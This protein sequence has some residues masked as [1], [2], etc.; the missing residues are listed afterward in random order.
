MQ[1]NKLSIYAAIETPLLP[2]LQGEEVGYNSLE[3]ALQTQAATILGYCEAQ[4]KEPA[5]FLRE[6]FLQFLS[7]FTGEDQEP[8]SADSAAPTDVP[9]SL[10][11]GITD[12]NLTLSATYQSNLY[13]EF[14]IRQLIE[15]FD[16]L[17]GQLPA[18]QC[19]LAEADFTSQ[20]QRQLLDSFNQ[21]DVPYDTTQTI[22]SLFRRQ[23]AQT[24][25]R[26]AVVYHDLS[27]TY[28]AVDELSER[29]AQ[30]ILSLGLKSEEVVS[31]L[32]PRSQWMVIASLGVLKAGCAYQPLDPSYPSE[33]LNFMMKDAKAR[34]LIAS[35]ELRALVD[36]Y[37]GEVLLTKDI[38][39]LP[40]AAAPVQADITP[41]SLFIL[42]YTSGSTGV[43]KGCQLEHG[44]LVAFCHWY[45][46]YYELTSEG[47]VA[48][49]ASYGFDAC[50]MDM[51]PALTCGAC[52]Y[53]IGDDIRLNLPEL[54][55]YFEANGITHSFITTQVGYQFAVNMENHTLKHFIVGG[56]KLSALEPPTTYKMHNGYG[57]T[58]CT[59]FTTNYWVHDYELD[60][61][62]GKPLDN[63]RLYIVD[64]Q[65]HRLPPGAS[66]ELWVGGPQ[67]SRGYLNHPDKTTEVF[68]QNPFDNDPLH[69]RVYRTGDIVR[70]LADGNIQF[71]GRKDSQ[72]KVR[73]FRIELKEVEAIIR[74]FPGIK[75]V[76][77]QAFDE[78]GGGKFLA[79]YI[80]S[81]QQVDIQALNQFIMEE[82]PPFMVPAV[83]MQIDSI[84]LNV[85][86]K[87]DRKALPKPERESLEIGGQAEEEAAPLNVLEQELKAMVAEI[88]GHEYFG[89]TT[90]LG[91][92]G[93]TSITAIRLAIQINKRFGVTL[94]SRTLAKTGTL[95]SIENEVLKKLLLEEPASKDA[96]EEHHEL[97]NIPLSYAQIGVYVDCIKQPTSIAYNLPMLLPFPKDTDAWQLRAALKTLITAHPELR[98]NFGSMGSEIVQTVDLEQP[99]DIAMSQMTEEELDSYKRCFARPFNLKQDP[100]YRFEIVTT[101]AHVN[102][103]FDIHHLVVDGSSINLLLHQ[104]CD[105]L[106]GGELEPEDL[107]YADYVIQE[108]A[109][110]GGADYQAARDFFHSQLSECEGITEVPSDLTNPHDEGNTATEACALDF[111]Q[112]EN[113]CRQQNITPA[114]LALAGVFYALSRFTNQERLCL[115]TISNGRSNLRISNTV[116]MFVNTLALSSRVTDQRVIDFLLQTSRN[117]DETIQHENYPFAQIAADYDLSPEIMYAYQMG[118]LDSYK[119]RGSEMMLETLQPESNN[120]PLVFFI[121][122]HEGKPSVCI[123]YDDGLYSQGLIQSLAQSVRNAI[124]AFM[125]QPEGS[126]L[127]V[128]LLDE[129]QTQLLDSFNETDEPFDTTQTVV[130]LFREQVKRSPDKMAVVFHDHR[131]TYREVDEITDRLAGYILSKGLKTEDVVSILIPRSEWMPLAALGVLKAG[132]AYQPLDPSYPTERLNFMVKD[133]NA[134]LLIADET[135]C[136]LVDEYEGD[137]L[138]TR[139]ILTCAPQVPV[140]VEPKPEDLFNLLY[141]SGSTGVPKGCQLEH[142]NVVAFCHM[143]WKAQHLTAESRIGAYA[144]FGFDA[145]VME[146]FSALTLGAELHIIPEEIRL[147]LAALNDY[148]AQNGLTH[149][150]MTTQVAYQFATNFENQSLKLLLA[151]GEKLSALNPPSTYTMANGYGPSETICFVT[152]YEV[153]ERE[154][155]IPIGKAQQ[156]FKCYVVDKMGH[157]LP[158]G[159]SGELWVA[160]PQVTR[161]YLNR[162]EKTAE[163][164]IDNPFNTEEKYARVY[165]TGD[166]VRYLP[167]GNL[168]YVGRRDGQVKI[169]GFRIELKE[170]EAVIRQFPGIKDATVQAFEYESGGKY[171]AAYIVSDEEVNIKELNAFIGKQKP[172]YMIPAAT[173]QIDAI[174][175]TQNQK[176]NRKA[177]PTP[178]ISA[179]DHAYVAPEGELEELFCKIFGDILLMDKIGANDSFFELGGTSLMVTRVMIE[180][181]KNHH[182]IAYGDLFSHPTPRQLAAFI[183]GDTETKKIN[184]DATY[185]YTAINELLSHN[186]LESF[187]DG[188]RQQIGNVLLTGA[189]GYL[190]IHI[191]RD[192]IERDD[193]PIIWCLV[194]AADVDK[195]EHRLRGLLFYYF[196]QS[197]KDLFGTRLRIVLGDVTEDIAV[198]GKVDTVFNCAAIVKH[199]SKGTEI[200]DVNIGGAEHCVKFCL[201]TGAKLVHV[202][203]Y[204]TA[205]LSVDGVPAPETV[206]TE[207]ML[208]FGQYLDNQYLHSKFISERIVLE[209]VAKHQ[210]RAKVVRLG[211][212]APRSTDGEFQINFQTNSAMGRIRV[213][214][215]LGCYPYEMTDEPMEFSPI[216]E[217]AHS[218]VL[219][220]ETPREC[221]VFHPFNNH[222]VFFGDVL[223][224]LGKIGE[225]PRQVEASQF[226]EVLEEAKQ[227]PEKAK[228]LSSMLAYQDM[229]HGQEAFEIPP[230]NG[231]TTQVL[232]RLGFRWSTTSWDYVDQFLTAIDGMGY[233]DL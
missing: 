232:Y 104:L 136:I 157:R 101:E 54:N 219:L 106:D 35:E 176:V 29:I 36:E 188:E 228:R 138:L 112:L 26:V 174:P 173:M 64:K 57:P 76:T 62:I 181:D 147:D 150:F 52:V 121:R 66:G 226:A 216:N 119:C 43:P 9:L 165:R 158:V 184:E 86:Q 68:L 160:G 77:V 28:R 78:T 15:S 27:Y 194:R 225:T 229:A 220:S 135:L 149:I 87:V 33:R 152:F 199:F 196:G 170:V 83:T 67:V 214:K 126:L 48:A 39:Q 206:L 164:F 179:A 190:G 80:V 132:C 202:S 63:L 137:V 59:I 7:H 125:R 215:M 96:P 53:I 93:L 113:F 167:D 102:L 172:P 31:I 8:Q 32:I 56:E 231:Y 61:P 73:G 4:G 189:T 195:A 146:L 140:T 161:G 154:E 210:L 20:A 51:Y 24:P 14:L 213:F 94:D 58:E 34:L 11:V 180:A 166:I 183:S 223:R 65:F 120:F 163:S 139:D 84:P 117:F 70:Y 227:D 224:E 98:V 85:N 118:V 1:T 151:G 105:L 12:T 212:L 17:L 124:N 204:S 171:I 42:L 222:S 18:L 207:Q 205:G 110:E 6:A 19:P 38:P 2:D 208:Y 182:H 203:T 148:I 168:Q 97:V 13:S 169:R 37:E 221:V 100:L 187:L 45:Q 99:I 143:N 233:F 175:L 193:V 116:G 162:P 211:N 107:N 131:Y 71:V 88:V 130:S 91:F 230:T 191:L 81:D 90:L 127:Q 141:T 10:E 156:N 92:A 159:A 95:Q 178:I 114:H 209:A 134:K 23:V 40:E 217:V 46:R 25:D 3:V 108:K 142:R 74:Q 186:N 21:T 44:N 79:A 49:Y 115:C 50:M 122:E 47:R 41:Q 123:E 198:E 128:S 30:H 218:I 192:L 60:I 201:Q 177:L 185:D 72:V 109:A 22:V 16:T 69:A 111:E 75:D 129:T 103:L 155:N 133:A 197:F 89:L 144:S 200:E 145:S 55:A 5:D 153:K 82:K